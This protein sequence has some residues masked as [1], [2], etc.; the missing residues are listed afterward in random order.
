MARSTTKKGRDAKVH[1]EARP[2]DWLALQDFIA[3]R[4]AI[5]GV[6]WLDSLFRPGNR[7]V[8]VFLLLFFSKKKILP[9]SLTTLQ[10]QNCPKPP[11]SVEAVRVGMGV[12]LL[13]PGDSQPPPRAR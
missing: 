10:H 3:S 2:F 9:S 13:A 12:V 11:A 4:S 6:A 1:E 5:S 8:K 7:L